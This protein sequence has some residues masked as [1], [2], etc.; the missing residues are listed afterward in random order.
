[1]S[2]TGGASGGFYQICTAGDLMISLDH[3]RALIHNPPQHVLGKVTGFCDFAG[4]GA[5]SVF[6]TCDGTR[7][8][9]I[10]AWRNPDTMP[11]LA[12]S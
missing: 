3:V 7:A 12:S 10:K 1:M 4:P 6:A 9:I 2:S 8:Q 11:A 5:E